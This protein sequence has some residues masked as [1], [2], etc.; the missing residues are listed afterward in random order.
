MKYLI[1]TLVFSFV[2][3]VNGQSP[4]TPKNV[5]ITYKVIQIDNEI[6]ESEIG[7]AQ[8]LK[9]VE[10]DQSLI[11]NLEFIL[12]A[13]DKEY[14][15]EYSDP[16]EIDNQRA[17]KRAAM[18]V[19]GFYKF[20]KNG[21]ARLKQTESFGDKI[22][23]ILPQ[24]EYDWEVTEEIKE[25]AGFKCRKAISYSFSPN[26]K[27]PSEKI[28]IK[29]TA[30]FSEDINFS[31]GPQGLDNLPGAVLEGSIDGRNFFYASSVEFNSDRIADLKK[32]KGGRD[33]KAKE[34]DEMVQKILEQIK[35]G[36]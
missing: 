17:Q 24:D 21:E 29:I 5:A 25:I 18:A 30:W 2:F 11:P 22:N 33:M 13:N 28:K 8:A 23:I 6:N 15:F 16:L 3:R 12:L 26:P 32:P 20:Y 27:E 4:T 1:I 7:N 35:N 34:F 31:V 36:G 19:G 10:Q 9:M 14:I